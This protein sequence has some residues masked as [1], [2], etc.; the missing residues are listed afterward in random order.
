MNVK[1]GV[2]GLKFIFKD[3]IKGSDKVSSDFK[4]NCGGN[5]HLC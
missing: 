3:Q 1:K 2:G 4:S 5:H